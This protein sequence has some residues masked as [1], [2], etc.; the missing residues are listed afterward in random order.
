[1]LTMYV[2]DANVDREKFD[3]EAILLHF[4]PVLN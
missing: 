1:M 2:T 3:E 4:I